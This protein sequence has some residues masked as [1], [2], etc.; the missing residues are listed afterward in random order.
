MGFIKNALIGIALYEALKYILTKEQP[1]VTHLDSGDEL[2]GGT[3]PE[4]PLI[5][6]ATDKDDP[7]KKSLANDD[8]RSPDS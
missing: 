4:A 6:K 5:G 2:M 7:W 8:L 1:S 3:D